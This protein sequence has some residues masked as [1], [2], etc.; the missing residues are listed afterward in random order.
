ML[1]EILRFGT[2]KIIKQERNKKGVHYLNDL[3]S[4]VTKILVIYNKRKNSKYY[5]F[6]GN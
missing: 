3:V 1:S 4:N 2:C 6:T 5:R